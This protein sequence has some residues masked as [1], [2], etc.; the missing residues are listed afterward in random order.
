MKRTN[1]RFGGKNRKWHVIMGGAMEDDCP[2][3][4]KL[5][6]EDAAFGEPL[7]LSE[8][9]VAFPVLDPEELRELLRESEEPEE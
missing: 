7:I 8:G 6:E 2:L 3:C 1:R 9:I 4:R 5:R